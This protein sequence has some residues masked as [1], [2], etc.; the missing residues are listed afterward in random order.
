MIFF[1]SE[2]EIKIP[3]YKKTKIMIVYK[4]NLMQLNNNFIPIWD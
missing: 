2:I 3:A 1:S 4:S